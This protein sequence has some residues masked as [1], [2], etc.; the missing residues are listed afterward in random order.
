MKFIGI[1]NSVVVLKNM[2][3]NE[4]SEELQLIYSNQIL[5]L[6]TE[7]IQHDFALLKDLNIFNRSRV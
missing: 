7:A 2:Y 4:P 1:L 3:Y 6:E 5:T